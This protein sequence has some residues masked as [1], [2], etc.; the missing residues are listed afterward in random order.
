MLVS[1]DFKGRSEELR[2]AGSIL[3][4]LSAVALSPELL[5][6]HYSAGQGGREAGAGKI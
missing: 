4:L 5:V 3:S 6:I 1:H 2:R